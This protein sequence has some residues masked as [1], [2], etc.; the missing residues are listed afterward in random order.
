MSSVIQSVRSTVFSDPQQRGIVLMAM[1]VFVF[2]IYTALT[3]YLAADFSPL[4]IQFFRGVFGLIPLLIVARLRH[5]PLRFCSQRPWLQVLRAVLGISS[6]ALFVLAYRQMPLADAVTIG[7]AA[8]IFVTALSVPLLSE[9]VGLH[10]WSAVV[11]GFIGVLIVA[12]PGAGMASEGALLA[13]SGTVLYA[14][15]ILATRRLGGSDSVLT[16]M[17]YSTVL[18]IAITAPAMPFLWVAP[19]AG[20]FLAFA[21]IGMIAGLGMFLFVEAYRLAPAATVAPFD[22]TA[23]GWAALFGYVIWAE[24]PSPT[25]VL[26]IAVIAA[27]GLYI[28]HRERVRGSGAASR[29]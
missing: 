7:Y 23:M 19:N 10:R 15:M 16:T 6:T 4:Q 9:K 13:I 11:V 27:A 5:E 17:L 14:L 22:Y 8:P 20:E 12:Q 3:K 1:A 25:T 2:S 21:M 26:G 24:V 18:Y 28:V 29:T